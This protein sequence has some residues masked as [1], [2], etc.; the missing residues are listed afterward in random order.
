MIARSLRKIALPLV[1][2]LCTVAASPMPMATPTPTKMSP[3]PQGAEVAFLQSIQKDLGAR[4]ATP[5]DA[6]KAGYFRYTNEDEDGAISYANLQWQSA[7]PQHPSQLW[8]DV[9]G[10]LLGA[11][12]SVLQSGSPAPPNLW[13]VDFHRWVSFREHIHYILAGANG[14]ETYG[15]TSAKKFAAAG[16]NVDDPQAAT[17]VKMGVVKD[18]AGVKK[19][20]LFPS[21]WDLI[22]WVK[23]N[24]AGAFADK[25]PDVIPSANAEK[26]D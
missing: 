11:D 20:F 14:T 9:K 6:V 13:G 21:V 15:A 25:N 17:L 23:P 18:A 7:D 2:A 24:P 3:F 12:F 16:G 22:V 8:Y 19:V 5:Q 26:A 1:A 10:N 4:F